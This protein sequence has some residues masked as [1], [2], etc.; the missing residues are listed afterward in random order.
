MSDTGWGRRG[1]RGYRGVF[2]EKIAQ[3]SLRNSSQKII[4]IQ[5]V[6]AAE[7]DAYTQHQTML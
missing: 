3:F 2:G 4:I 5:N 6:N 7:D 1:I